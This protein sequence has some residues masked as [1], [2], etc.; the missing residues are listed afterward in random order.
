MKETIVVERLV[1]GDAT[2]RVAV[3]ELDLTALSDED[4]AE[5]ERLTALARR[6]KEDD[7]TE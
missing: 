1:R 6:G 5:F 3:G 4:F 2:E 7:A